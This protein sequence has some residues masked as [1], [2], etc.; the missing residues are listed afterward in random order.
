MDFKLI[1][2]TFLPKARAR[3]EEQAKKSGCTAP[4]LLAKLSDRYLKDERLRRKLTRLFDKV[5]ARYAAEK[6][7]SDLLQNL[8]ELDWITVNMMLMSQSERKR[9]FPTLWREVHEGSDE[10]N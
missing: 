5:L 9:G 2:E 7:A 6:D 10:Q 4:E 8:D 1:L 3:V